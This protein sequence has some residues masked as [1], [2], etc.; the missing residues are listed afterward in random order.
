MSPT[1]SII[2]PCYNQENYLDE[3]LQSLLNQSFTDWECIIVNDGS[4]DHSAE[5]AKRW[6]EKD[7]RFIYVYK[8][9]GG[10]SSARNAGLDKASGEY[11]QFLDGDDI[12]DPEKFSK[13]LIGNENYELI[14]SQFTIYRNGQ[15]LP[16]YNRIEQ[17]YLTF[18]N[19]VFGWNLKFTIP[20]HCALISRKLLDGFRFDLTLQHNEDW[21]MW[22][23][24]TKNHPK[25]MLIDEPLA[26]YRKEND[27]Q[28]LSSDY[29]NILLRRVQLLPVLK[30]LYGEGLHDRLAYHMIDVHTNQLI[31]LRSEFNKITGGRFIAGYLAFKKYY[32]KLFQKKK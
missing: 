14:V 18:D 22:I 7:S 3:C 6:L 1:I 15:H 4:T 31:Q 30:K 13:S 24:I 21:L 17:D 11:V 26:H 19:I 12:L 25:A 32:Y 29:N 10:I 8:E 23:Y 27:T 5:V 9:N 20:I 16:G 28:S 2:V